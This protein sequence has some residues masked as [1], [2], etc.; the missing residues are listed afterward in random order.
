MWPFKKKS[1]PE[2][3]FIVL[4]PL[5]A[6]I[7]YLGARLV[8]TDHWIASPGRHGRTPRLRADY[9]NAQGDIKTAGFSIGELPALIAENMRPD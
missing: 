9:I 3:P 1:E 2:N 8:V 7:N 6:R 4:F 5:G